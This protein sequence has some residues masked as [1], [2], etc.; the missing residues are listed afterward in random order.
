MVRPLGNR[1]L[2]K[3]LEAEDTT[4]GGIVLPDSAR[5]KPQEA[6]V[7]AMGD[8]ERLESGEVVPIPLKAGD[9]VIYRNFSGTEI[10]INGEDHLI[11]DFGSVLATKQPLTGVQARKQRSA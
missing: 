1:L 7:V 2:V 9:I 4:A 6:E 8:G 3:P 11:L 5:K 10:R